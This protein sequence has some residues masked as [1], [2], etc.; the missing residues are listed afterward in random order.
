LWQ[1]NRWLPI[2]VGLAVITGV[3]AALISGDFLYLIPIVVTGLVLPP[4]NIWIRQNGAMEWPR[5]VVGN[6]AVALVLGGAIALGLSLVAESAVYLLV[7]LALCL[8]FGM[9]TGWLSSIRLE[10]A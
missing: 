7:N 1:T 3:L 8:I 9:F 2:L 5:P 4:F 6:A 10:T